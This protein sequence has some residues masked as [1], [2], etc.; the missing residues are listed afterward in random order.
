MDSIKKKLVL[1]RLVIR[2]KPIY[3]VFKKTHLYILKR[4]EFEKKCIATPFKKEVLQQ[5]KNV[6]NF[7]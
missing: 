1:L 5:K 6:T 7:L 3:R 4:F 2:E